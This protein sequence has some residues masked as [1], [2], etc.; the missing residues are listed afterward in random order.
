MKNVPFSHSVVPR[1]EALSW[2]DAAIDR[3]VTI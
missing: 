3:S 2:K 1:T